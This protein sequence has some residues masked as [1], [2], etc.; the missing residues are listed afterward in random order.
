MRP[1]MSMSQL[2]ET[3]VRV[4]ILGARLGSGA[5][6]GYRRD[7]AGTGRDHR[8]A[9]TLHPETRR[10]G[11]P[12][13]GARLRDQRPRLLEGGL[14][15]LDVLIRNV[16][17]RLE[18]VEHFVI[19]DLPPGPARQHI[20]GLARLPV[21]GFLEICRGL[22]RRPVI[23]GPDCAGGGETRARNAAAKLRANG[24]IMPGLPAGPESRSRGS[25]PPLRFCGGEY[26]PSFRCFQ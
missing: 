14:G 5:P 15:S 18:T 22:D 2:A 26:L 19:E 11:G 20:V 7:A 17:L 21:A 25:A 13:T 10:D 23:V 8:L 4:G 6:G 1:Q 12:E 24:L 16:D 9:L 3:P